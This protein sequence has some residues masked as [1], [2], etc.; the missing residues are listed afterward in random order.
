[1]MKPVFFYGLFMDEGLL[2]GK[3]LHP[4]AAKIASLTGYG[5]RIGER[6]TLIPSNQE[7]TYGTV[8]QLGEEELGI[9][10]GDK[11]VADYRPEE[12]TVTDINGTRLAAV[13]YI[14][15]FEK[16]TGQNRGYAKSLAVIAGKI[17]L[18]A[19]YVA[20]IETWAI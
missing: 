1:M 14:L 2:R 17:G 11:S 18:P 16:L 15:P 13:S 10:Y 20:E 8:I 7:Q 9:L 5:L 19:E 4:S 3:G 12:V 6:A